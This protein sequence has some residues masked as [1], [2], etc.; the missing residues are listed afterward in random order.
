MLDQFLWGHSSRV[1]DISCSR[2]YG[3]YEALKGGNVADALTDFTGGI[4]EGYILRGPNTDVPRNIVNIL[5]KALDRQSLIGCGINVSHPVA[6]LHI[7]QI[8]N[9]IYYPPTIKAGGI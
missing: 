1:C 6:R 3:S 8:I 7:T 2:L 5:F 9:S 4:T